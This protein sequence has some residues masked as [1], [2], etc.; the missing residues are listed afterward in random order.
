V[1]VYKGSFVMTGGSVSGNTV[2][3]ASGVYQGGGGVY[4]ATNSTFTMSG[5][6]SVSGNTAATMGGGIFVVSGSTLTMLDESSVTGNEC[7]RFGGGGVWLGN[8]S[9]GTLNMKG[10]SISGNSGGNG[11]GVFVFAGG[12]IQVES[13]VI[14][15]K[16]APADLANKGGGGVAIHREYSTT[17]L[18]Y[19]GTFTRDSAGND[20]FTKTADFERDE[21]NTVRVKKGELVP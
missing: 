7:H 9:A 17:C 18:G 3:D 4:L 1:A 21:V 6:S 5:R 8:Q 15:G 19:R 14:Y 20:I 12:L 10:G 13:G 11:A 2:T 16:D